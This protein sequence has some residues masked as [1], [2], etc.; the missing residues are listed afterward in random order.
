MTAGAIAAPTIVPLRPPLPGK[1][2]FSIDTNTKVELSSDTR[3]VTIYYT[4]N[5]SKPDPFPRVGVEKF[6]MQY[7]GPFT[8]PP[9][10]QTVK[11]LALAKDGMRESN[12]VTKVFEVEYIA[13]PP[14]TREDDD[15][16]GF[17]EDLEREQSRLNVKR[18]AKNMM[19]TNKTAWTAMGDMKETSQR[20]ADMTVAGSSHRKPHTGPRFLNTRMSDRLAALDMAR[21][22]QRRKL[23]DNTT[24]TMRLQRETDF[25]KCVYCFAD[26]PTDPY[27]KFCQTCGHP[28]PPLP[29]TR[30]PPPEPGQMGMCVYC[31]SVVPFNTPSCI[32]CEGPIPQQNQPQASVRLLDRIVC[33]LCGTANPSNLSSCVT[34]DERL[35]SAGSQK[36]L[37][38]GTSAPP[39]PTTDKKYVKCS[40]CGRVNHGEARFCDWCGSKPTYPNQTL[41][42]SKTK[43]KFYE[44]HGVTVAPCQLRLGS[45]IRPTNTIA[46]QTVGLFYPSERQLVKKK[47]KEED[48]QAFEKQMRDRKPLLTPVSPGRGYWRK[49][50]DHIC[51]HLKAHA[52]NDAEFRALIGEPKMGKL[53]TSTIQEDGYELSLTL[54][55]ALRG[56]NDKFRGK[57]LGMTGDYLSM[58]TEH[59]SY[60]SDSEISED[61]VQTPTKAKKTIK[62]PKPKKRSPKVNSMDQKLLKEIGPTGDGESSEVQQLLD[63]GADATCVNKDGLPALHVAV[64]NKRTDCIPVL[65]DA[66]ADVNRKGPSSIK[67]NTALHEAV[68]LGPAGLKVIDYLLGCNADQNKKNDRGEIPYDLAVKAGYEGIVKKFASALGQS[69]LEK[70]VRPKNKA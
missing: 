30:I 66:G 45:P 56:M 40:K 58:H 47:E 55:F 29:Q 70:M 24:Q 57:R 62:R 19:L 64:R 21:T 34:C 50:I 51:Q 13:Q 65:I 10:K 27:S 61:Y 15:D 49:Q 54:S 68:N 67:G 59:D 8:L 6:T 2:K 60:R 22:E 20:M 1:N 25:L 5:G 46:T 16:L 53:L 3:E 9:G 31:K 44:R 12:I 4:I 32:V 7:R 41:T 26:R 63:E 52:Q 35:T 23:P 69:H 39:L 11:A 38:S 48:K 17:Q 36:A 42:C 33:T 43:F 28:V 37:Y 18:A 14:L